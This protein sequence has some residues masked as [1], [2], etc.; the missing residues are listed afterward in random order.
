MTSGLLSRG[1]FQTRIVFHPTTVL[2]SLGSFWIPYPRRSSIHNNS[3][4][5]QKMNSFADKEWQ[6]LFTGNP[7]A[8]VDGSLSLYVCSSC[9]HYMRDYNLGMYVLKDGLTDEE[10][11]AAEQDHPDGKMHCVYL[12]SMSWP[13]QYYRKLGSFVHRCPVCNKRMH[14]GGYKDHPKCP[15][16]GNNGNIEHGQIMWD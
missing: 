12:Y 14:S 16:C 11:T 9:G 8:I 3:Q 6:A 4:N 13:L 2:H 10:L 15:K 5:H 1:V 7:K